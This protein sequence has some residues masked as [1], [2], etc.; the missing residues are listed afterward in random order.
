MAEKIELS[1]YTYVAGQKV[2]LEGGI[3]IAILNTLAKL[4]IQ[5]T[6]EV[7]L[8]SIPTQI[9]KKEIIWKGAKP[10]E[11]FSQEPVKGL[12]EMGT[13]VLDLEFTLS[14][15]HEENIKL[16]NATHKNEIIQRKTET[17]DEPKNSVS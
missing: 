8:L 10:E 9:T 5:E 13:L 6:K 11:F 12:T 14:R 3:L 7:L 17:A 15:V 16:G 1:D 2:E 4:K